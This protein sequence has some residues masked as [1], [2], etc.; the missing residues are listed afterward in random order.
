MITKIIGEDSGAPNV[1]L[2]SYLLNIIDY[3]KNLFLNYI[4]ILIN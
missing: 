3:L 2:S 1:E 4:L